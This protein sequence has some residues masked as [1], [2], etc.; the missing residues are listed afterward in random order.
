MPRK[1]KQNGD[2]IP[3]IFIDSGLV[4]LLFICVCM[5]VCLFYRKGSSSREK[6]NEKKSLQCSAPVRE[7]REEWP[8]GRSVSDGVCERVSSRV[9]YKEVHKKEPA[10]WRLYCILT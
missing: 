5:C 7:S 8:K 9:C 1:F 2:V 10:K 6:I 3:M 4:G